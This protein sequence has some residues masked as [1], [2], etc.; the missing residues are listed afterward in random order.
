MNHNGRNPGDVVPD[1]MD[2]YIQVMGE[3]VEILVILELADQVP[4]EERTQ[5]IISNFEHVARNLAAALHTINRHGLRMEWRQT[6]RDF[7]LAE[8][9]IP[10]NIRDR[11]VEAEIRLIRAGQN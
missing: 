9:A 8:S 10:A 4:G 7:K 11:L 6:L 3:L 2:T 1:Q 5:R